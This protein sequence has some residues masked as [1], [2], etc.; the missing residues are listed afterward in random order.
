MKKSYL[1]APVV[2]LCAFMI[3]TQSMAVEKDSVYTWGAWAEGIKPAAG[4]V[5][6]VTPPPA[7]KTDINFRPNENVAFLR[8]AVPPRTPNI[9]TGAGNIDTSRPIIAT[10]PTL[11]TPPPPAPAL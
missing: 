4:P 5:A 8:E 3:S 9:I 10:P 11:I 2:A 7:E 6:R 1:V